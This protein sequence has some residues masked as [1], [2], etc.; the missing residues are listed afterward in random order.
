MQCCATEH[1]IRRRIDQCI[2]TESYDIVGNDWDY[3]IVFDDIDQNLA[4]VILDALDDIMYGRGELSLAETFVKSAIDRN[5]VVSVAESCTGGLLASSIIDVAGAS[6]MFHEGVVTYSDLA[7]M[8][9]LDVN[10]ET[11][12]TNGAVSEETA[13]EMAE[14]LFLGMTGIRVG[15]STTGIAGPGGGTDEKPVGC[16]YI[17]VVGDGKA[18]VYNNRYKGDRF[19]I[20]NKTKN[21]ALFYALKYIIKYY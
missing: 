15:I 1:E 10:S 19:T 13:I 16:V 14:G 6:L 21:C 20:R 8:E 12:M 5:I 18:E 9:R 4:Y 17:A 11:I 3:T 2:Q 7:K